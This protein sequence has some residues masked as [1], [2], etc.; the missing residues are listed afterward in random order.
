MVRH[1]VD[2]V[3]HVLCVCTSADG[4]TGVWASSGKQ[5]SGGL[6]VLVPTVYRR[7]IVRTG[8]DRG[9]KGAQLC[10]LP[11]VFVK[12]R[13][14]QHLQTPFLSAPNWV[15][16]GQNVNAVSIKAGLCVQLLLYQSNEGKCVKIISIWS[17]ER[18]QHTQSTQVTVS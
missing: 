5:L 13:W 8:R 18:T 7:A 2:I 12:C 16:D 4:L 3:H 6:F 15:P 11:A 10:C 17:L 14:Q 9:V 1:N